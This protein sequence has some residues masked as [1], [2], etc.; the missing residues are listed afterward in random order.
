MEEREKDIMFKYWHELVREC[1]IKKLFPKMIELKTMTW[2]DINNNFC[3]DDQLHNNRLFFFHL[4]EKHR[5]FKILLGALR[6]SGQKNMAELLSPKPTGCISFVKPMYDMVDEVPKSPVVKSFNDMDISFISSNQP[7]PINTLPS[8]RFF[9]T[10][11][12]NGKINFYSTRSKKRGQVLILNNYKF[13][14]ETEYPTRTGGKVDQ[15]NLIDLF[16]QLNFNITEHIDKTAEE[17]KLHITNFARYSKEKVSD[18]CFVIIMSHGTE[19]GGDTVV[20]G[21]DGIKISSRWIEE[22]FNNENCALFRCKPKV[23]LYQVCRG[24]DLDYNKGYTQTDSATS[25]IELTDNYHMPYSMRTVEDML[26]GYSTLIGY[27]A[28]RDPNLGTWYI[29][30][31]CRIFSEYSRDT[32][33][34]DLLILVDQYMK[35]RMSENCSVQTSESSNKGFGRCYLHPGIYEENGILKKF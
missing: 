2:E 6:E 4:Q 16:T 10:V 18:I 9:D 29:D 32:H 8:E 20:C 13:Y 5:G 35:H 25:S 1:D 34:Q 17:M 27:K 3:T 23:L 14:N 19:M 26:I 12:R 22:Q 30:I 21:K 15:K 7:K 11:E 24:N 31:L 28:H 33:V